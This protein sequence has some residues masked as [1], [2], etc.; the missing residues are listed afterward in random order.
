[1]ANESKVLKQ[2]DLLIKNEQAQLTKTRSVCKLAQIIGW[3][4]LAGVFYLI[5][6]ASVSGA[7]GAVITGIVGI[8]VGMFMQLAEAESSGHS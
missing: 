5:F 8:I 6:T 1:M 4:I 2:L 7:T 3:L